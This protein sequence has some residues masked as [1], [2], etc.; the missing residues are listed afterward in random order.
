MPFPSVQKK[1]TEIDELKKSLDNS[2]RF[3]FESQADRELQRLQH[4]SRLLIDDWMEHYRLAVG[5]GSPAFKKMLEKSVVSTLR[6]YNVTVKREF[7]R[8]NQAGR[9]DDTMFRLLPRL[10]IR[11]TL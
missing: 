7:F 5:I 3:E 8:A 2:D 11:V 9:N 10:S 6:L 4:K 1:N